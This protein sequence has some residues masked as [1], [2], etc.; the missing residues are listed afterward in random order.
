MAGEVPPEILHRPKHGFGVPIKEWIN[1]Q[2]RARIRETLTEPRTMQ[3][4]IVEQQYV[5]VLL[6]EHERGRR[7]HA[8]EIWTL[9]MLELWHRIFIDR[10]HE[11]IT[12][13]ADQGLVPM[14]A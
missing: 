10:S 8:S 7:D 14:V 6:D 11:M 9:F 3:R 4:G 5:K 1:R 12:Q 13:D 2:L